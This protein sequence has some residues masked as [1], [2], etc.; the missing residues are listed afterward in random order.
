MATVQPSQNS[1]RRKNGK[2]A[3]CEPCRKSKIRCDHARPICSRCRQR[4]LHSQCFYHP[5]PLSRRKVSSNPKA[6][7][8][9][10]IST[11]INQP[12]APTLTPATETTSRPTDGA[13]VKSFDGLFNRTRTG[14]EAQLINVLRHLQDFETIQDLMDS[15]WPA[16]Q[17][18]ILP[19]ALIMSG[20]LSLGQTI[21]NYGA[22]DD[23][24]RL[25]PLAKII[26]ESTCTRIRVEASLTP[27]DFMAFFTGDNLRVEYLGFICS[28]TARSYLMGMAK[29]GAKDKAFLNS[30]YQCST[31]CL[32]LARKLTPVNDMTVWLA[33]DHATLA[34]AVE[35]DSSKCS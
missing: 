8:D 2:D 23:E 33:Q 16:S 14:H 13:P 5:A 26:I 21:A 3:S 27:G 12:A 29:D 20:M 18:A 30:L 24:D 32:Q 35:G 7:E 28:I 34:A 10:A 1:A 25:L 11:P 9:A 17:S 6:I 15:Y 19:G 31:T 22:A 4:S